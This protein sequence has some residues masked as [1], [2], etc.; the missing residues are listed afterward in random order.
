[1]SEIKINKTDRSDKI[2]WFGIKLGQTSKVILFFLALIGVIEGTTILFSIESLITYIRFFGFLSVMVSNQ[3]LSI[4]MGVVKLVIS[5]Y[6]LSICVKSRKSNDEFHHD[7]N[8]TTNSINWFGFALTQTSAI[9]L[10]F[11]ALIGI[12]PTISSLYYNIANYINYLRSF[13][14]YGGDII[15]VLGALSLFYFI[16]TLI[17][18]LVIYSYSIVRFSQVR[19]NMDR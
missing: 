19:K 11:L 7:M 2:R 16:S 3:I 13:L 6:T 4:I 17:S 18:I 10:F 14:T 8:A 15:D 5:C 9:I 1:M 12:I